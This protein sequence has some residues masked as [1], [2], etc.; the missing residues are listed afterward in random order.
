MHQGTIHPE[1]HRIGPPAQHQPRPAIAAL[2]HAPGGWALQLQPQVQPA[3]TPR[4]D[5]QAAPVPIRAGKGAPGVV[6]GKTTVLISAATGAIQPPLRPQ[7]Q[8][9]L[10]LKRFNPGANAALRGLRHG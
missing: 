5:H 1:F 4:P 10:R 9:G 7:I 8:P 2:L 3:A 6:E